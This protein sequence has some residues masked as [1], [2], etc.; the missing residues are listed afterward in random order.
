METVY[1]TNSLIGMGVKRQKQK[2]LLYRSV[3][4]QCKVSFI[5]KQDIHPFKKSHLLSTKEAKLMPLFINIYA[6]EISTLRM[7]SAV[8]LKS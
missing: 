5:P 2:G 1:I 7:D 3:L 4:C 8:C 6:P